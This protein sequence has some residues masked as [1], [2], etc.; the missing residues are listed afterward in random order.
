M[1]DT[2]Q[3]E[4]SRTIGQVIREAFEEL[5]STLVAFV[6]APKALWGINI[7]YVIEGLVYFGIL[8]ILGKY[9]SENVGLSDLQSPCSSSVECAT[10]SV[11]RGHSL[12]LSGC[13]L[14]GEGSSP[15]RAR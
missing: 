8:T 11:S 5:G 1:T 4:E 12:L 13:S 9:C 7:P 14:S 2:T 15:S 10:R 3:T 6:K